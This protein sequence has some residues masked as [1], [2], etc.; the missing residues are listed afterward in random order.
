MRAMRTFLFW[1]LCAVIVGG[2]GYTGCIYSAPTT[3]HAHESDHG[4]T[5][6]PDGRRIEHCE[7]CALVREVRSDG[8]RGAWVGLGEMM[9]PTTR[10]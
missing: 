8:D 5:L 3:N 6:L 10:P 2:V 4:P 7:R 1:M 9:G